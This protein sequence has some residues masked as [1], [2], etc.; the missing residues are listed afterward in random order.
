M[1]A[2][3]IIF[4]PGIKGTKLVNTNLVN[5]DTIW[6]A[7]QSNF[8][9]IGDL[10]LTRPLQDQYYDEHA[11]VIVEPG[12]LEELAYA[13]FI[14]DLDAGKPVYIFN[15]DWRLSAFENAYRLEA[16]IDY[17]VEKSTAS[18]EMHTFKSFD[19][20]THSLGNFIVRAYLKHFGF[21]RTG[22]VIFTVPPFRGSLDIASV[23]TVGEGF[24]DSVKTRIRKLIRTMPG[25]LELLPTYE[26]AG[27][28]DSGRGRHSF[29]NAEHWQSNITN[30]RNTSVQKRD[31]AEKFIAALK[32]AKS[33][34][35]KRL[36]DLNELSATEKR[37][38]LVLARTGYETW[39]SVR[40]LKDPQAP[41]PRNFIDF[42]H[43]LRND[44]G[45]G[46]VADA[47]SCCYHDTVKTLVIEDAFFHRDYSHGLFLK[48]ERVQRIVRKF[49]DN[50]TGAFWKIPGEAV[51]R[52]KGLEEAIDAETGLTYRKIVV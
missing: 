7:L 28:F 48:D 2:D 37:K 46:R 24:F 51:K 13:E 10:E 1:P 23:V 19:F 26:K 20:I 43:G 5:H 17:L 38:C 42:E 8:E 41:N 15:Y 35:S 3:A 22:K 49:L 11:D 45:D 32:E 52:V 27:V 21:D 44:H 40:V 30:T 34:V 33:T 36:L 14:R 25:A 4:V 31:N 12:E 50:E 47:S 39:Q 9:T 16:F 29:F 18:R 6:S